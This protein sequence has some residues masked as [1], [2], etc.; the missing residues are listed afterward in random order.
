VPSGVPASHIQSFLANSASTASTN[1][2][3]SRRQ[4][5]A[6]FVQQPDVSTALVAAVTI[7][8]LEEDLAAL[9]APALSDQE[10]QLAHAL[11]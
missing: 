10:M 1:P 5:G 11:L 8:E 4:P 9:A 7:D 3:R 2:E 6:N